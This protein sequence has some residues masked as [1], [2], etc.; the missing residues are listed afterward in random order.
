MPR[1]ARI[2]A[3]GCLHHVI[4]R[5]IERRDIF[6]DDTD[7]DRFLEHLGKLAAEDVAEP[8]KQPTRVKARSVAAYWA[9]RYLQMNGTE[10]GKRLGIGQSAVS[11]AGKRGQQLVREMGWT[12]EKNRKT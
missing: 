4:C 12:L 10:V 9:V 11:R 6:R 2:D 1:Q 7:R 3:P 5:G 8:G